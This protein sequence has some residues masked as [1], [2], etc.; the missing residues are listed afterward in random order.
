MSNRG[1]AEGEFGGAEPA[2]VGL[3]FGEGLE[4]RAEERGG[5]REGVGEGRCG[6]EGRAEG[7]DELAVLIDVL[8]AR[9][10]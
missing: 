4:V 2:V 10:G 7:I 3:A 1:E 5:G 8:G 6:V 9:R